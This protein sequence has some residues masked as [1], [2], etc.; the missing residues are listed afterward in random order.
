[1][2]SVHAALRCVGKVLAAEPTL[3]VEQ[4]AQDITVQQIQAHNLLCFS[5]LHQA[6]LIFYVVVREKFCE[7]DTSRQRKGEV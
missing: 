6:P 4:K 5:S 2:I 7:E 1:M 3:P